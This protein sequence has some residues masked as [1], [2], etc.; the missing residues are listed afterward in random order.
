MRNSVTRRGVLAAAGATLLAGCSG[1]DS[2]GGD[3]ET[4]P[5]HRLPAPDDGEADPVVVERAP[6]EIERAEL[7]TRAERVSDL[8]STLPMR[9]TSA[10]IPNGHVRKRLLE[11]SEHAR[12]H[13]RE[14]R[15]AGS[16]L[17]ALE[18]LQSARREARYAAAGWA[19]AQDEAT[20]AALQDEHQQA[21]DDANSLREDQAYRG[22]DPVPAALLH[23]RI[24]RNV[25]FVVTDRDPSRNTTPG[26]LLAVA[27]WG[28]Q[29]EWARATVDDS[30][31]LHDRFTASLSDDAGS[32]EETLAAAAEEVGT[33]LS[34]R[35]ADLP[36]EPTE[37]ENQSLRRL[38]YR[39][40]DGVNDGPRHVA[41]APGPASALL[42]ATEGFTDA[43][44]YEWA[45][46][47]MDDGEEFS[48]ETVSDVRSMRT[49]AVEAL[50]GAL[51]ESPRPELV[52]PLLA[53]SAR[54]VSYADEELARYSGD[55][56]LTR[57]DD[58]VR[59]YVIATARARSAPAACERVVEA[60]NA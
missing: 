45:T 37:G 28:E 27:E 40:R 38:R 51:K 43:L 50:R 41:D 20:E 21:V 47:R 15:T 57:L 58:P 8:L 10:D 23:A 6:V 25:H 2:S 17:A 48:P 19:F 29:A 33:E 56:R 39:L 11:A 9:F 16:R 13:V 4:V 60:L 49:R 1:L 14:A 59:R 52:R 31:Y 26:S 24:E 44:A 54:H 7:E 12:E 53:E 32:V 18:N 30:R 22:D 36:P 55:V 5:S 3:D 35:R 34:E 42:A 46:D